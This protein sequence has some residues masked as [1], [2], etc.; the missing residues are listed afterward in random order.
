MRVLLIDVNAKQSS[1]GDIV[2]ALKEHLQRRGDDALLCYARGVRVKEAGVFRFAY[3]WETA[4]H[5]LLTRI[6]GWTDC[7]SPFST[8]RL[9]RKIKAF[10]PDIIHLHELHSYF[11]NRKRFWRFLETLHVPILWTMH[12]E[13]AYTGRCGVAMDCTRYQSGCGACPFLK[14]YPKTL[15]FDHSAQMFRQKQKLYAHLPNLRLSSPSA[16]LA[17]RISDSFLKRLPCA[18]IPNGVHPCFAAAQPGYLRQT[19]NISGKIV[20]TVVPSYYDETK[21]VQYMQQLAKAYEGRD[22][23][24]VSISRDYQGPRQISANYFALTGLSQEELASAYRDSDVFLLLSSLETFSK[25]C[26]E[27][28]SAGTPVLGFE[29]GAPERVFQSP[30]AR[31]VPYADVDSLRH[32]LDEV[33]QGWVDRADIAAYAQAHFSEQVMIDGY[34]REYEVMHG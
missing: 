28:L 16:W 8:A 1:T 5:A 22:V 21:G 12:C 33:L 24:F 10:H 18:V 11:L 13:I 19:W 34:M 26:A 23:Y 32:K 6:T 7:F 15:F 14:N 17:E 30:Y 31:F 9:L 27:A 4:L 3:R 25:T 20:L 2:Y 29:S